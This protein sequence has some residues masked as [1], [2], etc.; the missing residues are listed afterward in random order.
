MRRPDKPGTFRVTPKGGRHLV[1]GVR[2]DG[3]RVKVWARTEDEANTLGRSLFGNPGTETER[4]GPIPSPSAPVAP[5]L[6]DWGFPVRVTPEVAASIN[7][8]FGVKPG[9]TTAL[10]IPPDVVKED[11]EKK[12]RRAK[13]AKSLM[14]LA[15]VGYAAGTVMVSKKWV[16]ASGRD[17]V[18]VNP[19]QVNDLADC[20]RDTLIEWFGDRDI[21]P[22]QMMVILSFGIPLSM[23]LQS[24]KSQKTLDE[25]KKQEASKLRSV[26]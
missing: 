6:D 13:H 26:P 21:K 17:P 9:P 4:I 8:S 20:T 24:P 2:S 3:Q 14:E 12:D 1:S 7:A 23:F 16:T 15:G 22:W 10:P 11:Q 5:Q 19:R 25:E 18:K